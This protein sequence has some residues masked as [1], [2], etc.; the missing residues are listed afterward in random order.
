MTR[1]V[2][3]DVKHAL[4]CADLP[5]GIAQIST[6][7]CIEG[8]VRLMKEGGA[9]AVKVEGAAHTLEAIERMT[10]MGIPVMG[11]LGLTPQSVH[12]FGGYG[13]RAA[14]DMEAER[15]RADAKA[16]EAAG[17][18]AI[19]LEKI[20]APLAKMV[21]EESNVP[22]IGI[23]SGVDCDGQILVSYDLFGLGPKFRFVRRYLEL[24]QLIG[25]AV[26]QYIE[27]IRNSEFPNESESYTA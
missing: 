4:L 13:L 26:Q 14:T 19:V 17:V 5:F 20:P 8:C 25:D 9:E 27:D 10:S 15:L 1:N 3:R 6:E 21:T 7:A 11:H 16:L 22:T 23:G 12:Q 24:D 18:F 2:S